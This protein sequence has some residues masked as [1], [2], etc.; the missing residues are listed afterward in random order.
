MYCTRSLGE[1]WCVVIKVV[2]LQE[3]GI[4][5]GGGQGSVAAPQLLSTGD[6]EHSWVS[7]KRTAGYALLMNEGGSVPRRSRGMP[8]EYKRKRC[9]SAA[10]LAVLSPPGISVLSMAMTWG[11]SK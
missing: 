2:S 5:A 11:S 7:M 1:C 3:S 8:G 9:R 10:V 6:G 4:C